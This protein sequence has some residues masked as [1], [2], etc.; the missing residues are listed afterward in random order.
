[1]ESKDPRQGKDIEW[2]IGILR[3]SEKRTRRYF[4]GSLIFYG[5]VIAFLV[6]LTLTAREASS[7][8]AFIAFIVLS[9]LGFNGLWIS[10]LR[11]LRGRKFTADD[12]LRLFR[13]PLAAELRKLEDEERWGGEKERERFALEQ[14]EFQAKAEREHLAWPNRILSLSVIT[15]VDLLVWLVWHNPVMALANQVVA[16]AISQIHINLGPKTSLKAA[17]ELKPSERRSDS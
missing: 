6:F 9:Y 3:E 13:L 12:F 14:L 17:A 2:V 16:M 7:R 4:A 15:V 5:L 10:S 8:N 1:M 11:G